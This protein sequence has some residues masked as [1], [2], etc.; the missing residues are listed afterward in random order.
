MSKTIYRASPL[1]LNHGDAVRVPFTVARTPPGKKK[2][3][4]VDVLFPLA[5]EGQVDIASLDEGSAD[6][7]Y[8]L[9]RGLM[10]DFVL[11][12][13]THKGRSTRAIA[14]A[15][16]ANE[17]GHMIT[18][19]MDDYGTL[20]GA[21]GDVRHR[22]TQIVGKCPHALGLVAQ[23]M[24]EKEIREI[25]FAF[26]DG[27][28]EGEVLEAEL[29]FVEKHRAKEC[30]VAVDNSRDAM[31]VDVREVMDRWTEKYPCIQLETCCGF[32][33]MWMR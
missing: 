5:L 12:T 20:G 22:V 4:T 32:D 15:L 26:L 10:P 33:L 8:G 9:V 27:G 23:M 25:D 30:W 21:V 31:W 14:T 3:W 29:E 28:H 17:Q 7:L 13:G 24:Q 19:D 1:Q 18:V 11:E 6:L 2:A 16:E